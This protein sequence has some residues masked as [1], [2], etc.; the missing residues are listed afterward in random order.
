M[1][2]VKNV[3]TEFKTNASSQE[4]IFKEISALKFVIT[5]IAYKL[6]EE[7]RKQLVKELST[8]NDPV[9]DDMVSNLKLSFD[10]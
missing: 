5:M 8:L 6:D 3:R 4:H 2:K 10:N 1:I 9:I 7:A